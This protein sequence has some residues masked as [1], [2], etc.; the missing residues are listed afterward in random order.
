VVWAG[1]EDGS[2]YVTPTGFNPQCLDSSARQRIVNGAF[3]TLNGIL[4]G[5]A[6]KVVDSG[7]V[8]EE[9]VEVFIGELVGSTLTLGLAGK[10]ASG[11]SVGIAARPANSVWRLGNFA[12][13]FEVETRLF[14]AEQLLAKNSLRSIA[15][16]MGWLRALRAST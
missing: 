7:L 14:K 3:G 13:G 5:Q 2:C 10:A 15:S 8:C 12:R 16:L 1:L 4:L 9:G 11:A 6:D